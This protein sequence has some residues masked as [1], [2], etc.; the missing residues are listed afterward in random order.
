MELPIDKSKLKKE[1][2][3]GTLGSPYKTVGGAEGERC[4]YPTRLDT[5]GKGCYYNCQY[6]FAYFQKSHNVIGYREE[7]NSILRKVSS[8]NPKK[9]RQLFLNSFN[10]SPQ[11]NREKEFAPYLKDK[12]TLQWGGMADAFDENERKYG[13]SLE[14]LKFF[15]EIDY[16]LSIST[17]AVWFTKDK[18]Y[19]N[20]IKKH[21]HNWHFKISIITLD[22]IKSRVIEEYCPT[23]QERLEAIKRLSDIG[24]P[25]TLRLRPYIIGLSEDYPK[26]IHEAYKN[27]A[28]SVTT[29]FFCLEARADKNLKKKY[30]IMSKTLGYDVWEFY[31]KNSKTNGYKRLNYNIKGPIINHMKKITHKHKM[32]FYVSDAHHKEK[33]DAVCCCGTPPKFKV[34]QGHYSKALQIAKSNSQH[35][36]RWKDIQNQAEKYL[37]HISW[38]SATGFNT[39]SNKARGIRGKQSLS[40]YLRS[41][42]NTP[43]NSKSPYKYFEGILYPIGLDEENN[44]IYKYNTKKARS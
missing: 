17:K 2:N 8:V 12:I 11:N 34:Y 1:L 20:I 36:V 21:S 14:L 19:M 7:E 38:D 35:I 9:I 10:D 18:R 30:E 39:G 15:D 42:W 26:L 44:V 6:C 32:L 22:P 5:Y 13:V 29:E 16:P 25:V 33:C 41:I 27:G 3:K 37:S 24:I 23:P 4:Y 28:N 43:N 31:K 40:D